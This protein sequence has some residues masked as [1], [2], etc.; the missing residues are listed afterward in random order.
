MFICVF[1]YYGCIEKKAQYDTFLHCVS[2][3][4]AI[5][6][7]IVTRFFNVATSIRL[8]IYSRVI[9][10]STFRLGV[11]GVRTMKRNLANSSHSYLRAPNPGQKCM[12]FSSYLYTFSSR[13]NNFS[14][15]LRTL[16]HCTKFSNLM[17][18]S[19]HLT[20]CQHHKL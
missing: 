2:D 20:S 8:L 17:T 6:K 5:E 13:K 7:N 12:A 14:P 16:R 15:I 3:L 9:I 18:S 10:K 1:N 4:Q 19:F 11:F